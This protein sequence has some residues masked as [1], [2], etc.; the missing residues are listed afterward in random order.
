MTSIAW[1]AGEYRKDRRRILRDAKFEERRRICEER[2][3]RRV[4]EE[5]LAERE[6]LRDPRTWIHVH[7][8]TSKRSNE[9]EWVWMRES[10][11]MDAR[12]RRNRR[13]GKSEAK[14]RDWAAGHVV[15][16]FMPTAI[17]DAPGPARC[18]RKHTCTA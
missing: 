6:R 15:L 18:H 8:R 11:L 9:R 3:E 10:D 1:L 17:L 16:L 4:E 5:W 13:S 14:R 12:R 7:W 2:V